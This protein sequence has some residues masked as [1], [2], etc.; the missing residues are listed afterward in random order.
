MSNSG[1]FIFVIDKKGS[2][3]IDFIQ[4][5]ISENFIEFLSEMEFK[6]FY[7]G[8]NDIESFLLTTEGKLMQFNLM[9][10]SLKNY[11]IGI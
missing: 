6:D 11:D 1:Q 2:F 10:K 4:E 3:V 7:W 9:Q 8:Q 5:E